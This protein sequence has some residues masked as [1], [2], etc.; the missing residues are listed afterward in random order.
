MD[1]ELLDTTL[2]A[3]G[4]PTYRSRQARTAAMR[5]DAE[6]WGEVST[7]SKAL[8]QELADRVPWDTVT[9]DTEEKSSDGSIKLRLRTHDG[10]PLEAVL[11]RFG[12][13]HT[14]CL[15]SQSG[16]ALA[17]TFCATGDM[18]LGRS[19]T[20]YEILDQLRIL[21]RRRIAVG[22]KIDNVVMMGMGE[23][24]QNYDE[25]LPAVRMMND[26]EGIGM[27]A[28]RIAIS[29]VGWVP[30]ILR[31]ADEGI[32]VKLA[33]SLHAPNDALRSS[34]MPVNKRFPIAVLM[35][36]CRTYREK[37]GRRIFVEYLMLEGVNDQPEHAIELATLLGREGYHVN[38]IRYNPTASDFHPSDDDTVRR[39]ARILEARGVESSYR[40]SRGRDISAACGQLAAP[41]GKELVRAAREAARV[42]RA[43]ERVADEAEPQAPQTQN[44]SNTPELV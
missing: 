15:S 19:L 16:C 20:R 37:T 10:L 25:V 29:T 26:P 2:A 38:L 5:S 7:L 34:I 36:A 33:L 30:G 1:L 8:R 44:T 3:L 9:I 22:G 12:Q 21:L 24:F 17:C 28:R 11:M 43:Q 41:M 35:D 23:P 13:R 27:A 32:Q 42:A 31:L 39:F 4:E 14:A 18:G 40:V 6:G